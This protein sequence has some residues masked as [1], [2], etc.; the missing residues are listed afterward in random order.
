MV[1]ILVALCAAGLVAQ[2]PITTHVG[3]SN[4]DGFGAAISAIGDVDRDG[5]VDYAVTQGRERPP[6]CSSNRPQVLHIYSGKTHKLLHKVQQNE[7]AWECGWGTRTVALGDA[8][9]DGHDDYAIGG[10]L[11]ASCELRS[12][13][14]HG[15][16]ILHADVRAFASIGDV[17]GDGNADMLVVHPKASTTAKNSVRIYSGTTNTI[18]REW[19][20]VQA[21]YGDAITSLGDIDG[22]KVQ[23]FAI[24]SPLEAKV[25]LH[26]G[27]T[28]ALLKTLSSTNLTCRY[29]QQIS[30]VGDYDGDTVDDFAVREGYVFNC[31]VPSITRIHSGKT[32]LVLKELDG[33]LRGPYG[34]YGD[35]D[36]DGRDDLVVSTA[37]VLGNA[38]VRVL[39]AKDSSVLHEVAWLHHNAIADVAIAGDYDGDNRP[40]LLVSEAHKA[41][42][43]FGFVYSSSK[44]SL[45]VSTEQISNAVGGQAVFR[46]RAGPRYGPHGRYSR[47][48]VLAGSYTGTSPGVPLGNHLLPLTP[49]F[50]MTYLVGTP[51]ALILNNVGIN[52][53]RYSTATMT[54]PK[55]LATV[56]VGRT[57]YHA[58]TVIDLHPAHQELFIHTSNAV[59]VRVVP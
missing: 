6:R 32:F 40:E 12:G 59:F 21:G 17:N 57:L 49:D 47:L 8:D 30:R 27:K 41:F 54:L 28:G 5:V 34:P 20:S 48:Y 35:H 13:K 51:N 46:M 38:V 56:L 19:K 2:V 11:W 26:S 25:F 39:S 7:T 18:L 29:G 4:A 53:L 55:G 9:G 33:N 1:F 45:A 3:A 31:T 42:L 52:A 16:A 43:G 14:T 22:D 36:G 37:D 44:R 58:F 10:A 15:R 23:D 50:Y 24:G